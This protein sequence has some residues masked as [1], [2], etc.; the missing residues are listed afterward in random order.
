[1]VRNLAKMLQIREE[2]MSN[3]YAQGCNLFSFAFSR[4]TRSGHCPR[5]KNDVEMKLKVIYFLLLQECIQKRE[6]LR[7][8]LQRVDGP[9]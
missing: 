9:Y 1:M 6:D 5:L 8:K 4:A 7:T 3:S 2:F